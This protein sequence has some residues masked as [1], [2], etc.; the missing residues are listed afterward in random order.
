MNYT[1]DDTNLNDFLYCCEELKERPSK[2]VLAFNFIANDFLNHIKPRISKYI[3]ALT[4]IIPD[5]PESIVNEKNFVLLDNG[6]YL[7]FSHM[8]KAVVD[9]YISSVIFYYHIDAIDKIEELLSELNNFIIDDLEPSSDKIY[10]SPVLTSTLQLDL[11]ANSLPV[12][13]DIEHY[14]NDSTIKSINKLIKKIGKTNKGLSIIHGERGTGKTTLL[15]YIANEISKKCIF[16][17][18]N[19][20]DAINN[21]GLKNL[22]L[23][24]EG[25]M[26][27][28]SIVIVIDDCE[29]LNNDHMYGKLNM[30][31]ANILQ[32]VD[33]F[34][35]DEINVHIILAFNEDE[36]EE[37]DEDL[38]DCNNLIDIIKVDAL[39]KSKANKLLKHLSMDDKVDSDIF[40][41]DI[42]KNRLKEAPVNIGYQ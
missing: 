38:L 16:I 31:Y 41:I 7:S 30:T 28:K 12:V 35:S 25:F 24:N 3:N 34:Y 40:L 1:T 2:V 20:I 39:K 13:E 29:V 27:S 18:I 5:N 23:D 14:Y 9:T 15:N 22:I 33:G 17:P 37:I 42:I 19:L 8:D 4:E 10:F 11:E 32:M 21:P 6:I 36:H 26:L